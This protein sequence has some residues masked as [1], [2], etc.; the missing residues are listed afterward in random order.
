MIKSLFSSQD[1]EGARIC[2]I[3]CLFYSFSFYITQAIFT[4]TSFSCANSVRRYHG[5][6]TVIHHGCENSAI[7]VRLHS[8]YV[9]FLCIFGKKLTRNGKVVSVRQQN[10]ETRGNRR[11]YTE[12]VG[13]KNYTQNIRT[14]DGK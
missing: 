5:E 1:V 3:Q 8:V 14:S 11:E 2:L 4:N 9:L 13:E 10:V 7:K 6:T 12:N